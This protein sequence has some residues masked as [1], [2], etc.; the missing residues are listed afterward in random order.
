MMS[1]RL[2]S[3]LRLT[4]G[5]GL[6]ATLA[7]LAGAGTVV[8]VDQQ[9]LDAERVW[10]AVAREQV[11]TLTIVGDVFARP[12]L[13]ALRAH[14]DRWDL[15]SLRAITS[16]GVL[17]SPSSK[18]AIISMRQ[19]RFARMVARQS[20]SLSDSVPFGPTSSPAWPRLWPRSVE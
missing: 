2:V 1:D 19:F 18:R 10:D 14:P 20:S 13:D 15:S 7:A 17:F 4:C 3:A 5:T 11:Q 6:F 12:L 8:L 9:G 16:S